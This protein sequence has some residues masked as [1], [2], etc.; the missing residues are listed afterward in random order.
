[1]EG[2]GKTYERKEQRAQDIKFIRNFLRQMDQTR[3]LRWRNDGENKFVSSDETREIKETVAEHTGQM[4]VLAISLI[5]K[6]QAEGDTVF[7][8]D[9]D[10]LQMMT[11]IQFHDL[12]E[13]R[14]GDSRNKDEKYFELE[15]EAQQEIFEKSSEL[16]FGTV[17]IEALKNYR[18]KKIKEARYVK[19]IDEIQAW[20]FIIHTRRFD[21]VNRNFDE[22]KSIP[23]YVYA[24][25]FPTLKRI[26]DILLRIMRN[27]GLISQ[28]VPEIELLR[29]QYELD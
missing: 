11:M 2:L 21:F 14:I 24:Q 19:A 5:H 22:P 9:F 12:E 10:V 3:V 8:D 13:N 29:Q 28:N 16:N 6:A 18:E 23:G 7:D 27:P 25:E 26:A 1:M 20:I 15:K 17:V 4:G